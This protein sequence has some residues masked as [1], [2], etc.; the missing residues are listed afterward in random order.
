MSQERMSVNELSEY[1]NL[2]RETVYKYVRAGKIP[3]HKQGRQWY[4]IRQEID[5]WVESN[6]VSRPA[7]VMSGR[8]LVVDDEQAVRH[9]F[10][11]WLERAGYDVEEAED[12]HKALETIS[13]G[14]FRLV[15]MDLQMPNMDG[16]EAL[17][18]IRGMQDPPDVVIVT[19]HYN[20]ALM[21]EILKMGPVHV[22][23]KP[24]DRERFLEAAAMYSQKTARQT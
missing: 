21:E 16:V 17:R 11:L 6:T 8:V 10:H 24:V 13:G 20:G 5:R 3:S 12:G 1:L 9:V 23:K 19:A 14:S 15:F 22:L 18:R 4:F 2:P 7:P